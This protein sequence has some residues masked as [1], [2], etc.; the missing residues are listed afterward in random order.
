[1]SP[2]RVF[3]NRFSC[4]LRHHFLWD[5]G[6]E[7]QAHSSSDVVELLAGDARCEVG[8]MSCLICQVHQGDKGDGVPTVTMKQ[9]WFGK[10]GQYLQRTATECILL[11]YNQRPVLLIFI[12]LQKNQKNLFN[13]PL[14]SFSFFPLF[15]YLSCFFLTF[16]FHPR[17]LPRGIPEGSQQQWLC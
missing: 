5:S 13:G 4:N 14:S 17:I 1:M 9:H 6:D 12:F 16:S 2:C 7:V 3:G 11:Y 10:R 8:V 15:S